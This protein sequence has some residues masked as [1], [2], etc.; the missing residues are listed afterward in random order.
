M[1]STSLIFTACLFILSFFFISTASAQTQF[2][3]SGEVLDSAS[4]KGI[5]YATVSLMD[6]AS[7][8]VAAWA[9][10]GNGKFDYTAK[11]SGHYQ[12]VAS[13]VGYSPGTRPITVSKAQERLEPILLVAGVDIEAV[14]VTVTKP[15]I[16]SEID[17]VTYSVEADPEA[18]VS[19]ALDILRKVPMIS[20]DGEDNVQ[21]QGQ[22]NFKVL[23]NGKS[24]S[25][26]DQNFKDVIRG[27]P[28]S[29]VKDIEV[30]TNPSSKYEAEGVG[31][32]INI[33]TN[34]KS[35]GGY[36]GSLGLGGDTFGG[37]NGNAY[38]SAKTGKF[39]FSGNIHGG[40]RRRPSTES[41]SYQENLLSETNRYVNSQTGGDP[42]RFKS[43]GYQVEASYEIDTFNLLTLAF[44]GFNGGSDFNSFSQTTTSD[45]QNQT[46]QEFTNTMQS[47]GRF[48]Y[49]SGNLDY[50]RIFK[51]PGQTFTVSYKFDNN[52]GQRDYESQIEG[53]INYNS[54]GQRSENDTW[55]R[56]HTVQIDYVDPLSKVSTI[57]TGTKFILRQNGNDPQTYERATPDDPWVLNPDRKNAL[58]YDQ[59][60]WGVYG[61]YTMK[62][63]K[64]SLKAGARLETTWN[65]GTFTLA[66]EGAPVSYR[67]D[68]SLFN[69]I[70]YATFSYAPKQSRRYS[71]AYTQRLSRPGIWYMNPYVDD[72]DPMNITTGN[73]NLDAEITHTVNANY[74]IYDTK[75]TFTVGGNA[76]FTNNSIEQVT[77]VGTEGRSLTTYYN[78]GKRDRYGLNI[79][80]SWRPSSKF[81]L[82]INLAGGYMVVEGVQ[83]RNDGFNYNG[84]VSSRIGLWKGGSLNVNAYYSSPRIQLQG[85]SA[86]FY[87]YGL[88]V[89]QKALKDKVT[90]NL[91]ATNPFNRDINFWTK[92]QTDTYYR[93]SDS[94]YPM[95]SA[96]LNVT[97]NFGKAQVQ[98]KK[99][100]RSIT[101]DDVKSGEDGGGGGGQ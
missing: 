89:S 2:K 76:S 13:A 70:P 24:S 61:A 3:L 74:G 28:A 35:I 81:S 31:G 60:I 36:N 40:S 9:C 67:L 38:L 66:P 88:G 59:Y 84:N 54:Y 26:M 75:V 65:D 30:I 14:A 11:V 23:V 17:K 8:P 79:Y 95:Q 39:S 93:R 71:V 86:S 48:G 80:Y 82:N 19:T 4:G 56:A 57:E 53:I 96:R 7:R 15:L 99:A 16:K 46:V 77:S 47:K 87:Y 49:L 69:V 51:K 21:L 6:S 43:I 50:Q 94:W 10:D 1:K 91:S 12:L 58:D 5:G 64:I 22:S 33:I 72:R 18:P 73:P 37:Y 63:K 55:S 85:K 34:R 90:F 62:I 83:N 97:W 68:N 29:S 20:V 100:R 44:S 92:Q 78:V 98:V 101:N 27:M 42:Y 45:I 52:P 41:Q 32:I 25:L